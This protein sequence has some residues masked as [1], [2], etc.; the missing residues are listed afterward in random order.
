MPQAI[1]IS[2]HEAEQI[3][4]LYPTEALISIWDDLQG[5]PLI[6][7]FHMLSLQFGDLPGANKVQHKGV[8]YNAIDHDQTHQII[9]FCKL[10]KDKNIIIHCH[11]GVSRSS[12]VAMFC[13]I[14]FGHTL[15]P[16]FWQTSSPNCYILGYLIREYYQ[17]AKL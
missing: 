11:A 8:W 3:Q 17:H 14:A 9:N 10:N 7:N 16:N 4:Q 13:H 2:R 15:K 12:A 1:N 5:G 6:K